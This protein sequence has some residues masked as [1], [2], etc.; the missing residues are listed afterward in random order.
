MSK[1]VETK[2]KNKKIPWILESDVYFISPFLLECQIWYQCL[3]WRGRIW[4]FYTG[5]SVICQENCYRREWSCDPFKWCICTCGLFA[6]KGQL[7]SESLF[8]V[9]NFPKKQRKIQQISALET[10]NWSKQQSKGTFL[11]YYDYMGYLMFKDTLF[12]DLTTF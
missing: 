7:I 9:L 8:G 12:Y 11:Y 1:L 5:L 2:E 6:T 10:K 4:D 3:W